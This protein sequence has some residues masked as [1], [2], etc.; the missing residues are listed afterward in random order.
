MCST[1]GLLISLL[2]HDDLC[3]WQ[4]SDSKSKWDTSAQDN[5]NNHDDIYGAVI[6]AQRHCESSHG[7]YHECRLSARWPPTLR[8]SQSTWAV[9]LP[10]GRLLSSASTIAILLLLSPKADTHFTIPRRVEGWV[11]LGTAAKVHKACPRLYIAVAVVINTT[12]PWWDSNLGPL[13][14]Q[15]D[16]LTTRPLRPAP[17]TFALIYW[18]GLYFIIGQDLRDMPLS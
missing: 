4:T 6:M 1:E 2:F 3:H 17:Q 12:P 18:Y 11:D 8:P 10:V 13:T 16:A 5:N 14:P 7:S 15:S 9:S